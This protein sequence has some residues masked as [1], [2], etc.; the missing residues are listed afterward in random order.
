MNFR[1]TFVLL[2]LLIVVGGYFLFFE[3]GQEVPFDEPD[4]TPDGEIGTILFDTDE[5][6]AKTVEKVTIERDGQT[7]ILDKQGT[8]W[9]QTAPVTFALNSWS[10]DRFGSSTAE[11]RWIERFEPGDKDQPALDQI[12][13]APPKATVT[14]ATGGAQQTTRTIKLGKTLSIG[15]RGYLMLGEDASKVYLVGNGLHALVLSQTPAE[16]RSKS[17][18]APTEGQADRV[19]LAGRGRAIELIKTDGNWALGAPHSGRAATKAVADLC[20][21]VDSL[22]VNEFV[23]DQPADLSMY[24]LDDPAT[25]VR[26]QVPKLPAPS[27]AAA[28]SDDEQDEEDDAPAPQPAGEPELTILHLGAPTDLKK[29]HYFATLTTVKNGVASGGDV[30]FTVGKSSVEKFDKQ[31]DDLRDPRITVLPALEVSGVRLARPGQPAI[32]VARRDADWTFSAEQA[33]PYEPDE[34]VV[35]DLIEALTG[36]EADAYAAVPESDP[37][38]TVTLTAGGRPEPDVLKIFES[39]KEDRHLVVRNNEATGYLVPTEKLEGLFKPVLALRQ[40]TVVTL[41]RER[42]DRIT[43]SQADGLKLEFT[44][45]VAALPEPPASQ[46][47]TSQPAIVPALDPP[48]PWQLAG[49]EK[50]ELGALNK[51]IGELDPV[52]AER[53]LA[54]PAA[55]G[56]EVLEVSLSTADDDADATLRIDVTTLQAVAD[57]VDGTFEVKQ[58]LLDALNAEFRHRTVQPVAADSISKV[59]IARGGQEISIRKDSD[60]KYVTPDHETELDQTAA[61]AVFDAV[62]GL[63][64]ERYVAALDSP[65]EDL[66]ATITVHARDDQRFVLRLYDREGHAGTATIEPARPGL[67]WF[68]LSEATLKDLKAQVVKADP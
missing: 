9:K 10:A 12:G 52:R 60:A 42:L 53:W 41:P 49:H 3:K 56:D 34:K 37:A 26:I 47:A 14:L 18:S 38:V 27:D 43:V 62:A 66:A 29:E 16:W 1:T 17:L 24:G 54:A 28:G 57:G 23:K 50:L 22:Y 46:P 33:P 58:A 39:E 32:A 7:V 36:A 59:T 6:D 8:D 64:A 63:R 40:R 61:G 51:L 5:F 15:G 44:R 30:V 25:V 19:A 35:S 31:V 2:L 21:A 67:E 55:F 45:T 20:Q 4:G 13:L 65:E 68:T 11:L 48:G